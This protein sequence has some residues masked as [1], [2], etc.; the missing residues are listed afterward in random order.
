MRTLKHYNSKQKLEVVE[1]IILKNFW[2]YYVI[3]AKN[4]DDDDIKLC[5]VIGFETEIGYVSMDEI[6]PYILS[7]SKKL[8]NIMPPPNYNWVN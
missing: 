1:H 6:K 4:I 2:E 8:D 3:N 5:L 7:R